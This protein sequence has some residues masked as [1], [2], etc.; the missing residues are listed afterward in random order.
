M[1]KCFIKDELNDIRQTVEKVS[2]KFDQIFYGK[3]TKNWWDEIA[4]KNTIIDLLIE[5]INNLSR[6]HSHSE[7]CYQPQKHNEVQNTQILLD[8]QP[9]IVTTKVAKEK[10]LCKPS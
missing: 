3:Y 1:L 6:P 10:E 9:F 5:N 7:T 4:S 8:D 2:E